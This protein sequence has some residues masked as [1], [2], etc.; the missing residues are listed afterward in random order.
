MNGAKLNFLKVR[1]VIL[2]HHLLLS[3]K[4]DNHKEK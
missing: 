1:S 3:E 2:L 4:S